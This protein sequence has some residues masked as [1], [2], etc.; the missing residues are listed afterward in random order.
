V[1]NSIKRRIRYKQGNK[2]DVGQYNESCIRK[3]IKSLKETK[4]QLM[5]G[6][7]K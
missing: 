2:Y 5:I 1:K 7:S 3:T 4:P 6:K